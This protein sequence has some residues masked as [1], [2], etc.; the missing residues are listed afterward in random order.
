MGVVI[1][2]F[3]KKASYHLMVRAAL[4]VPDLHIIQCLFVC[5]RSSTVFSSVSS[6]VTC[7]RKLPSMHFRNLLD[8]LSPA[9]LDWHFQPFLFFNVT[10]VC[11]F[12]VQTI[13][14]FYIIKLSNR[15]LK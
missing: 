9:N 13:Q 4:A 3:G 7:V 8:C 2:L 15:I 1:Q 10:C 11:Y 12:F 14:S 5:T 6:L